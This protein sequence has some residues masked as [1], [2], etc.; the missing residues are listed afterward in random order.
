MPPL[1]ETSSSANTSPSADRVCRAGRE[2]A[3]RLLGR[4]ALG[5]HRRRHVRHP[6][7]DR[8]QFLL[9]QRRALDVALAVAQHAG[10]AGLLPQLDQEGLELGEE[11]EQLAVPLDEQIA[12]H[13]AVER[14]R[15]R[16]LVE[17][18]HLAEVRVVLRAAGVHD[19]EDLV[20]R[21]RPELHH[22]EVA[23]LAHDLFAAQLEQLEDDL[24][25]LGSGVGHTFSLGMGF[26]TPRPAPR[27]AC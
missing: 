3:L 11:E 18:Q 2:S 24:G 7:R 26:R 23:R 25:I 9:R 20:G 5:P 15:G 19:G 13:R 12:V 22:H 8:H 27:P 21:L 14:Q 1:W 10:V 17:G 6:L 16:H 4:L